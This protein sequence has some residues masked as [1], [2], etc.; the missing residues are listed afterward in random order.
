ML[1]SDGTPSRYDHH[2][3]IPYSNPF[4]CLPLLFMQQLCSPEVRRKLS[5]I[6]GMNFDDKGDNM[7]LNLLKPDSLMSRYLSP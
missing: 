7:W 2:M 1:H 3:I 6:Y 4:F 5:E